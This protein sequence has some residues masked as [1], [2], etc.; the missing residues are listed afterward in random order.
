MILVANHLWQSTLF[1]GAAALLTLALRQNRA[2][3]RYWLWLAA[4]MKFLVPFGVLV[5]FGK[6]FSGASPPIASTTMAV[7]IETVSQPLSPAEAVFP[8][9]AGVSPT[10]LFPWL[11]A[12][13]WFVGFLC[14]ALTWWARWRSLT[15]AARA[16]T[17]V[18]AGREW[19]LLCRLD[20]GRLALAVSDSSL[21]PGVFGIRRPLLLWPRR[22]SDCLT[23]AQIEAIFAHELCHVR[24]RDNLLAALHMSVQAIFWFYPLVWWIGA[25]L[26]EERER[27]CDEE[28]IGRG[29]H[30]Q[31]YAESI[32]KTCQFFVESPLV[33][34]AGVTGSDLKQRIEAI[35]TDRVLRNV[36]PGRKALLAVAGFAVVAAPIGFG[37]ALPAHLGAQAAVSQSEQFEVASIKPWKLADADSREARILASGNDPGGLT[38][39]PATGRATARATTL[40]ALVGSAFMVRSSRVLGGPDW[41]E[42]ERFNLEARAEEGSLRP[43]EVSVRFEQLRVMLRNLLGKRFGLKVHRES[44]EVAVYALTVA[45]GGAKLQRSTRDC[46]APSTGPGECH[47]FMGGARAG[48]RGSAAD[49]ADFAGM[50]TLVSGRPVLERTGIQGRFDIETGPWNPYL[51][52]VPEGAGQ[53]HDELGRPIDFNTL[54]TIFTLLPEKFGLKLE[55]T[56]A[57]L[58]MIVIDS[59]RLPSED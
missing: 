21:E 44:R 1:L 50:L 45:K 46:S 35:M 33:C 30:P 27:A 5:A 39:N 16:A 47:A 53:S 17:I 26:V 51:D 28:V 19:A 18:D 58:D 22:I 7:A 54:P 8:A 4:S 29:G 48:M 31:T 12:A 2:H 9:A 57:P 42:R 59:A 34:V 49:M 55:P 23:D 56:R 3:I 52:G 38:F 10:L 32:L 36:T 37:I 6:L 20:A 13:I 11:L 25:R 41:I 40:K 15:R 24:R 43:G 14:V